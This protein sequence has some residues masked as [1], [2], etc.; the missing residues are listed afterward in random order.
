LVWILRKYGGKV[1][2][3]CIWPRIGISGR[4]L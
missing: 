1:W 2:R 3:G 4:P